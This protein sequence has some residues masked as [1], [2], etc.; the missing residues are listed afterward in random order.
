MQTNAL[1]SGL[2]NW[3]LRP[4][5]SGAVKVA[6]DQQQVWATCDTAWS[7]RQ[8]CPRR[9]RHR[10]ALKRRSLLIA[11]TEG[12]RSEGQGKDR[13]PADNRPTRNSVMTTLAGSR[14]DYFAC[15]W[16]PVMVGATMPTPLQQ[17]GAPLESV[18]ADRAYDKEGVN[19]AIENH[20]ATRSP[21]VLN[22]PQRHA[23]PVPEVGVLRKRNRS[24]RSRARLGERRWHTRFGYSKRSL[25]ENTL[26]RHAGATA[27]R[28]LVFKGMAGTIQL[29]SGR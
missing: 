14:Q 7:Q 3:G 22:P 17:I 8:A 4:A 24:I 23:Q 21:R 5:G 6:Q 28:R 18:R 20:M 9:S 16:T 19:A 11:K 10:R 15:W 12:G 25:V 26:Y 2:F 27:A 29:V 1:L 13:T